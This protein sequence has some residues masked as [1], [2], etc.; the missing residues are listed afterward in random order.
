MGQDGMDTEKTVKPKKGVKKQFFGVV[1]ISLGLL[2]TMLTMKASLE[3]DW[4]NY[5]LVV[6]GAAFLAVGAWQSR[7]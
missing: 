7:R 3:P 1:L 4:F 2:N 5:M 6:F